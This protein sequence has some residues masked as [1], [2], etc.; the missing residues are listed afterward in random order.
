MMALVAIAVY[1]TQV[2]EEALQ[3]AEV[4]AGRRKLAVNRLLV[5]LNTTRRERYV[6]EMNSGLQAWHE[7][8]FGRAVEMVERQRPQP[9]E[10]DL[11]GFEWR[12]LWRLSRDNSLHTFRN[13]VGAANCVAYSPDGK[14]LAVGSRD[15]QLWDV[16]SKKELAVLQDDKN[17]GL[18][19][20]FLAFSPD[21]RT[22]A[23]LPTSTSTS[24]SSIVLWDVATRRKRLT[25]AKNA[26][27]MNPIFSPDGKSLFAGTAQAENDRAEVGVWDV[28]TG[29][30]TATL[31]QM[32]GRPCGFSAD[33]RF[34][35]TTNWT[36]L[37]VWDTR[38]KKAFAPLTPHVGNMNSAAVSPRENIVAGGGS[39]GTVT[40]WDM[41]TGRVKKEL[42]GPANFI[43]SVAFSPDGKTLAAGGQNETVRLWD[44][45]SGAEVATF[46]GHTGVVHGVAF[47]PTGETLATTSWDGTTKL[48]DVKPSTILDL[49]RENVGGFVGGNLMFSPDSKVLAAGATDG[50]LKLWE[51]SSGRNVASFVAHKGGGR[52][53]TF[54]ANGKML[55]SG[56]DDNTVRLWDVASSSMTPRRQVA[57][58]SGHSTPVMRVLV[59]RDGKTLVTGS[60]D[61]VFKVWDLSSRRKLTTHVVTWGPHS[62]ADLS[63]DGKTLTTIAGDTITLWELPAFRAVGVLTQR[64]NRIAAVAFSPD[65]ALLVS[66]GFN[67]RITLWDARSRR[68]V[69]VLM[70]QKG[71]LA[72]AAFS[73]DGRTLATIAWQDRYVRLWNVATRQQVGTLPGM[74]RG[75]EIEQKRIAFS[76]DGNMLSVVSAGGDV[77]IWRAATLAETDAQQK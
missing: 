10:E 75:S 30:R 64:N 15:V 6:A 68:E 54:L 46:R 31:P 28:A 59:S 26:K 17:K 67:G 37:R 62:V 55:I 47:S 44:V 43:I 73:P 58:L 22:L 14:I 20:Y 9:G 11:R 60:M 25:L 4:D 7:G 8:N 51:A 52:D 42:R 32:L 40:L 33:G 2:A 29:R 63:P 76:P 12:L 41:T 16:D 69:G 74:G 48:W 71:G 36:D 70:G 66:G 57:A 5:S 18:S 45:A 23:T 65:G 13:S 34:L 72:G 53:V 35:V 38:R 50:T 3:R 19:I 49:L 21:G 24:T 56:G 1:K 61:G 39:D 77:Y 27:V